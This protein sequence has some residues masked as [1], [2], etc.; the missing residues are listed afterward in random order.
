MAKD[1]TEN[2]GG[3]LTIRFN[4]LDS[5]VHSDIQTERADGVEIEIENS[6]TRDS[7]R[8]IQQTVQ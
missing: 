6:R 5:V 8:F 4:D 7:S 2:N 3:Q 1:E